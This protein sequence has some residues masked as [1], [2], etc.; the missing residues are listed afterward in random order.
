MPTWLLGMSGNDIGVFFD[1]LCV[2]QADRKRKEAAISSFG[3]FIAKSDTVLRLWSPVYFTRLWC[4]LE[5]AALVS[6]K[7]CGTKGALPLKFL[8]L[9][10][11]KV[12]YCHYI[13]SSFAMGFWAL[14]RLVGNVFP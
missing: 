13:F 8:P 2:H 3:A 10:L 6:D 4:T 12:A 1:K 7:M 11:Y 9:K 14:N 5:V